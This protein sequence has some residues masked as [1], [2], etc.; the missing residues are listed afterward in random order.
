MPSITLYGGRFGS[1]LRPHWMLA[2]LG[3]A[4]ETA[5]LDVR[6]GDNRKPEYLAINPTGQIPAMVHDGF[7]LTESAAMVNFLAEKYGPQF[8]GP[9]TP[10]NHATLLRWE[11]FALLNLDKHFATLAG[12]NWGR[13]PAPDV[14][15]AAKEALARFLP[16]LEGWL[17]TRAYLAGDA[18][19]VADVVARPT[20]NYAEAAE[21]DLAP[22][23]AIRA[24]MARCAERPAYAKAKQG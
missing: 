6:A 19:T 24:W 1:S 23:P 5:T 3:L 15:A 10:E 21:F 2:E 12:K 7:V 8:F 13:V 11:F 22:Y 4:Y 14:E 20:F 18:F 16:V 9:A 17:A